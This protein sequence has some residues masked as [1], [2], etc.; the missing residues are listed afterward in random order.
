MVAFEHAPCR[1]ILACPH[2]V[3]LSHI[4]SAAGLASLL[5]V[6]LPS[7]LGALSHTNTAVALDFLS[8]RLPIQ[9]VLP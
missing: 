3:R 1:S 5:I 9:I 7:L 6:L 4:P 2:F 8:Q